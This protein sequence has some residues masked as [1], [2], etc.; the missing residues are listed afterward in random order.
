MIALHLLVLALF[1][2]AAVTAGAIL[3]WINAGST[4][5]NGSAVG[6]LLALLA[7]GGLLVFRQLCFTAL[8]R[9]VTAACAAQKY[10]GLA[11]GST[12]I[13]ATLTLALAAAWLTT[14]SYFLG[15]L[16]CFASVLLMLSAT[17]QLLGD[18]L[19][20]SKRQRMRRDRSLTAQRLLS[21]EVMRLIAAGIGIVGLALGTAVHQWEPALINPLIVMVAVTIGLSVAV[22]GF[23]RSL[24]ERTSARGTNSGHVARTRGGRE[25]PVIP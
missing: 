9:S 19:L 17:L 8:T 23:L 24:L 7:T 15:W 21:V 5:V 12:V 1:D 10:R 25:A 13:D 18:V 2:V 4:V 14:Q 6:N 11:M 20:G 22:T 3:L 16:L